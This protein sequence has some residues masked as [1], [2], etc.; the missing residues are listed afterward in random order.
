M[1]RSDAARVFG[2]S[3]V[4]TVRRADGAILMRQP[5]ALGAYPRAM[6]DR[7][8]HWAAVAPERIFL[9]ER[10]AAGGWQTITYAGARALAMGIGE[11]LIGRGLSEDRPLAIL[12]GNGLEHAV[13]ALASMYAGVPHVPISPAYSLVSTDHAKLRAIID[14][15]TP[16]LVFAI[17]GSMF[18]KA[19]A[20]AIPRDTELVVAIRPHD[21]RPATLLSDLWQSQ[22]GPLIEAAHAAVGPDT[23]VKLLFTSG[24][25]GTPKGVINTQRMLTSNQVMIATALPSLAA[26]PPVIVDWLPWSHTFGANHNLGLVLMHGGT[27]HIDQGRPLPGA[28]E[29]TVANLREIAPT[30]YFNVPRGYE[31]LLPYFESDDA[32][33]R[34][35]FSRLQFIFYAAASLPPHVW[36]AYEAMAHATTGRRIPF[37]TSLGSTETAPSATC[38]TE[39]AR[40]PGVIGI[41]NVGAELKLVPSAGKLEARLKGPFITPGYW[42]QPKLTSEAF[43][44]EGFYRLG[45][46]LRFADPADPAKG[47]VF[48]GRIAEDFKLS[49]GTFVSVGPL[50]ARLISHL[51]PLIRDVVIAGHDRHALAALLVPEPDT[52]RAIATDAGEAGVFAS[53]RLHQ[54]LA[55]RLAAFN[56]TAGG[57]SERIERALML[58]APLSIDNG[59][60]TD[61]GSIN[62]RAVLARH[63]ALVDE[64]YAAKPSARTIVAL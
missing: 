50:R 45:D 5:L 16:G 37:V 1:T 64:L 9:A 51:A 21:D 23:I 52:C 20:A 10:D 60:L 55:G 53:Q 7:L 17:D 19:I 59:E 35:F 4:E 34:N 31:M 49:T 28:I 3:A 42:R 30:A 15:V 32:L 29:A 41:P 25:T 63:A 40:D 11:A 12:S 2:P 58:A 22:P 36:R 27:L 46:A 62:Q 26:T 14:L 38:A 39:I 43:D 6:T 33:R 48:D 61:K 18:A 47:L 24:S 56:T 8:D 54:A 13:L 57:S 44:E